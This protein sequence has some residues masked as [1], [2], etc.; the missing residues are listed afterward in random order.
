MIVKISLKKDLQQEKN[1]VLRLFV[2]LSEEKKTGFL[3]ISTFLV[4]DK[5]SVDSSDNKKLRYNSHLSLNHFNSLSDSDGYIFGI[6]NPLLDII[7][8]VPVSFLDG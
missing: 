3:L 6:G 8:E 1:L 2:N 5:M 7:A 4:S